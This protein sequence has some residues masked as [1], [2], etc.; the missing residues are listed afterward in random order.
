MANIAQ[1]TCPTCNT[2]VATP[3]CA[4]CGESPLQARELSLRGLFGHIFEATTNIDSRLVRSFRY[5][6]SRPG[7]LTVAYLEGRR[8][9][10]LGPV[11]LFLIANVLF[12]AVESLTGGTIFTAPLDSHLH[13]QPWDVLAQH[14]VAHRLE[15]LNTTL[16]LYAP[17]FDQALALKAR[18][19]II[20]MALCF[21]FAP[22]LVFLRGRRRPLIAH[23]VFSLH[24]FAFLLLLLCIATAVP[25]IGSLI[26]GGGLTS[27]GLDYV[28]IGILLATSAVYLY[29]ATG[30][31]Y[32]ARGMM[33][34]L[35]TAALTAAV[36]LILLG[37]RFVLFLITLYTT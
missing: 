12:F 14:L 22:A 28:L 27:E 1:W 36:F 11:R 35:K 21:A 31:V 5:L 20:L 29:L 7:I 26:G 24:F 9:P 10:Y 32:G 15:A 34:M 18:S 19:L 17:G 6:V 37:Y 33:R 3:F 25:P 2:S 8:K 13:T 23:A 4:I 30:A 16:A